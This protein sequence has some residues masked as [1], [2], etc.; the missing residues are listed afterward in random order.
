[1]SHVGHCV[2]CGAELYED[3]GILLCGG[4]GQDQNECACAGNE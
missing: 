3:W 2:H 4:C 1:M